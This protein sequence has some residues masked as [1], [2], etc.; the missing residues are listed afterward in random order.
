MSVGLA[1]PLQTLK[2]T[3]SKALAQTAPLFEPVAIAFDRVHQ[4]ATIL[5]N[6]LN[7]KGQDVRQQSNA[8]TQVFRKGLC[9]TARPVRFLT[10]RVHCHDVKLEGRESGL[11]HWRCS[12]SRLLH[13]ILPTG[14]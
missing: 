6:D 7:L 12:W 11:S 13:P 10:L 5:D 4:A 2:Q 8:I 1:K 9:L 14:A 3:R